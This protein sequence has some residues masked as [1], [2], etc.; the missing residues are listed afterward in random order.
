[1][2]KDA[3]MCLQAAKADISEGGHQDDDDELCIVCWE[4]MREV[5]LCPSMHM[6]R[7]STSEDAH[8]PPISGHNILPAKNTDGPRS[9]GC[10]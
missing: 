5:I 4:E 7:S 1:M 3:G 9:M 2:C 10:D 6:V 8:V